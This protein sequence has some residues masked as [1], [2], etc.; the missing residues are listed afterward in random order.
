[1]Q[2]RKESGA[3]RNQNRPILHSDLTYFA[4]LVHDCWAATNFGDWDSSS[5]ISVE[6]HLNGVTFVVVPGSWLVVADKD[7]YRKI[8]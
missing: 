3:P 5:N 8:N 1:M 2:L 4:I 7:C 6:S